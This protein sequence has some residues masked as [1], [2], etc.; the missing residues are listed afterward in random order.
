MKKRIALVT[1]GAGFIGSHIV[2]L[3]LSKNFKVIVV[4]NLSGGHHK[5]ISH[6]LNNKNFFYKKR[7][8]QIKNRI[9][10]VNKIDFIFIWLVK[11]ILCHQ[12]LSQKS[13]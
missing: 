6:N 5:N 3:L 7:Y 9:R 8:L 10:G 13:I 11:V 4:D 12:L 2:D 1:G